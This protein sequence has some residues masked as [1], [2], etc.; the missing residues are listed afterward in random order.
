MVEYVDG[1]GKTAALMRHLTKVENGLIVVFVETKR[2]ADKLEW[3]LSDQGFPA[4]SIHGDRAQ[5]EREAALAAFKSGVRPILVATDV[6][7][8]GLDISGVTHVFNYDMPGN[9]EDYVHRIG[10]TGRVGHTGVAVSFLNESNRQIAK[11]LAILLEENEQEL[12]GWLQQMSG[13]G[14]FGGR[15]RG[16]GRGRGGNSFGGRDYRKDPEHAGGGGASG[17]GGGRGGRG[18]FASGGRS[19]GGNRWSEP[20][21]GGYAA[22]AAVPDNSAW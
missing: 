20:S 12:P 5:H 11:D 7:S 14:G 4:T 8:R 13:E 2:A 15:G 6:A 18:G 3:E 9:I 19:G 1:H 21:S 17:G 10:R 22:P 16:R